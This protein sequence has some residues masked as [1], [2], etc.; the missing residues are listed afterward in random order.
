[1]GNGWYKRNG[2]AQTLALTSEFL[3]KQTPK[4]IYDLRSKIYGSNLVT[5]LSQNNE[6]N[7]SK[8]TTLAREWRIHIKPYFVEYEVAKISNPAGI[9][10]IAN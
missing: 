3:T 9:R 7:N 2:T 6:T 4:Y 8:Q 1:M 10:D 5:S